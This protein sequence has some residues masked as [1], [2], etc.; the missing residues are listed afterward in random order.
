MSEFISFMVGIILT[1][2]FYYKTD[3]WRVKKLRQDGY[4]SA[5]CDIIKFGF[6]YN[7]NNEKINVT[8]EE[9]SDEM[10]VSQ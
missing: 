10:Q 2:I 3:E 5:V 7:T 9:V 1:S 4:D 6:Y 8:V